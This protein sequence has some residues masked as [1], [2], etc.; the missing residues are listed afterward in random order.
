ML[1]YSLTAFLI[2]FPVFYYSFYLVTG[3]F[4]FKP[5]LQWIT[6][7]SP[8]HGF[9]FTLGQLDLHIARTLAALRRRASQFS[10]RLKRVP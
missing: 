9:T 3:S 5:F 4:A 7:F 8:E 10:A 1:K 2:T 6:T